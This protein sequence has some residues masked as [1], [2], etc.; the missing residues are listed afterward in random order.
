MG[1]KDATAF[2]T[3][4]LELYVQNTKSFLQEQERDS[5]DMEIEKAKII[6]GER[7]L[8]NEKSSGKIKESKENSKTKENSENPPEGGTSRIDPS[9]DGH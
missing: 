5:I 8:C 2:Y 3:M 6:L 7:K 9:P 1:A 4:G